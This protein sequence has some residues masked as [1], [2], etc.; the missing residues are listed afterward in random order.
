MTLNDEYE[1]V[2]SSLLHRDLFPYVDVVITE[3]CV[4]K[5]RFATL[6]S[7]QSILSTDT[8]LA[9]NISSSQCKI[10]CRYC[11]KSWHLIFEC[12]KLQSKQGTERYNQTKYKSGTVSTYTSAAATENMS[13][14]DSSSQDTLLSQVAHKTLKQALTQSLTITSSSSALSVTQVN[15]HLGSLTLHVAIIWLMTVDS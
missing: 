1:K 2:R 13:T 11:H 7:Q 5:A 10:T 12:F 9:T 4:R 8:V 15:L 3:L 14:D 6:K